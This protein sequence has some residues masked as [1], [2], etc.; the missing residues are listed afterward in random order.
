M[1][2]ESFF[3]EVN[4]EIRQERTRA[5]WSRFGR[6]FIALAVLFVIAAGAYVAWSGYQTAQANASGDRYLAAID[7]AAAGKT[8]EAL[9]AFEALAADGHGA[10]RDLA[11]MRVATA[12]EAQGDAEAAVKAFDAIS[13]DPRAP[14]PIRD[15]AAVRAA[16]VLVDSGSLDDV[17]Q[18]VERLSGDAE[19]LRFAA[20]EALG[21]AAWKAG[22]LAEAKRF[23]EQIKDDQAA[24]GGIGLRTGMMLDLVAAGSLPVASV[25]A[26]NAAAAGEA[27]PAGEGAPPAPAAD[28]PAASAVPAPAAPAPATPPV[29]APAATPA[30]ST[31]APSSAPAPAVPQPAPAPAP[32]AEL[33]EAGP[34]PADAAPAPA[35]APSGAATAP[36]N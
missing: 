29:A 7:L 25:P 22:D 35:A 15:M 17:R 34:S 13:G 23:F 3:R 4:E 18:R 28:A 36:A 8:G 10:Y 16:Y 14:A 20:R 1:S 6:M 31:A 27:E 24:P 21:L 9:T 2:D 32:A 33:P 19:P 11:W 12:R 5:L 26:S 30:P